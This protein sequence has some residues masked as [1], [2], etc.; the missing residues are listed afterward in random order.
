MQMDDKWVLGIFGLVAMLV[1]GSIIF[2]LLTTAPARA[3]DGW[4][5]RATAC[6]PPETD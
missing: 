2:V 3:Q 6:K 4:P 5:L 1:S